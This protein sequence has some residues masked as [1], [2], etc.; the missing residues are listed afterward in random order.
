[1]NLYLKRLPTA[2]AFG[3]LSVAGYTSDAYAA[4]KT[5]AMDP[6]VG[7]ILLI[8][9]I[10]VA[11]IGLVVSG[12]GSSQRKR[13]AEEHLKRASEEAKQFFLDLGTRKKLTVMG[14]GEVSIVLKEGE[15]AVFQEPSRFY[16][17]RSYR[18]YGGGG[19]RIKGVYVGGGASES[20]QRLREIDTGTLVLTNQRLIFDGSM[21][22]RAL[23]LKDIISASA[24]T[25]A[26]EVS[27]SRRQKSQVYTIRNPI[28]WAQMIKMLAGGQISF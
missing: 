14:P 12:I 5:G 19:T 24:W 1:M 6:E 18:L 7:F 13:E 15:L 8:I 9:I 11:A 10:A 21:E 16:E 20:H 2:L 27:S 28:I 22:N 3:A 25:D 17:T 23:N 4:K 26:I